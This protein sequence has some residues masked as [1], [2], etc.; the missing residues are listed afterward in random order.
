MGAEL[1]KIF[2]LSVTFSRVTAIVAG[3]VG[4]LLLS[5][6]EARVAPFVAAAVTLA[7]ENNGIATTTTTAADTSISYEKAVEGAPLAP[8]LTFPRLLTLSLA[9]FVFGGS[10]YLFVF[11]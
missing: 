5:W 1:G 6:V 2:G 3:V 10:M 8:L 4:V 7:T 11:S 9:M